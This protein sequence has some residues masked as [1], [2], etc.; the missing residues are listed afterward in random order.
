M[1]KITS[2]HCN[3]CSGTRKHDILY[4][5]K[6]KW[7]EEIDER[8]SVE[9]SNTYELLKCRGCEA[10]QYRHS[11][12]FSED[13]DPETGGPNLKI[14]CYPPPMYRK[15]PDW[16]QDFVIVD[17][18]SFFM[19]PINDVIRSIFKEIYIALQNDAPQLAILGIRA[20]LEEVMIE[21]VG[22]KGNFVANLK[23]FEQEGFISKKQKEVIEPVI[24]A[25]HAA[26]H[27]GFRPEKYIVSRLMDVTE[28]IIETIY[29]NEMRIKG[30][31]KKIPARKPKSKG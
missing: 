23:A 28:S 10:V 8:H 16:I 29:V 20:L 6:V 26:M 19:P 25:G 5:D 18:G 4:H 13:W 12:W 1:E 31:S 17:G 2:E 7:T 15:E 3:N 21:K 22:D 24:E 11:S 27:R 9:G 14:E 30:I